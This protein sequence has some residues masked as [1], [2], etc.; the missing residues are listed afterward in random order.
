VGISR[1]SWRRTFVVILRP[2]QQNLFD[3]IQTALRTGIKNPLVV[4]PT[5]S[6]KT[7]LFC[8]IASRARS[9][10][11]DTLILVHRRELVTQTSET[12]RRFDV[13]HGIIQPGITPSLH[14]CV[15]LGMV[16]TIARRLT[17]ITPPKLIIVDEAHHAAAGQY[18]AIIAA[19][20]NAAV[21]GFTA[22]PLRLD[23]KGLG[24][25]FGAILE[26][27]SVEWL[28]KNGFL[29]RP[30]Y[31]APPTCADLSGIK[32]RAGDFASDQLAEAMTKPK[33]TG[34]VIAHYRKICPDA[35]A[36][37]FCVTIAHAEQVCAEFNAAGI[38]S[39]IISGDMASDA[40]K[41]LVADFGAGIVRVLVSVDVVS[42]G[43]D[44]PAVETAILLRK[45]QSL[46]LYL[47]QVGRILRPI[48][49]KQAI[50]L[51]HVGNIAKHGLAEDERTWTLEGVEK[52]EG[53]KNEV[54]RNKQ[55]TG[56]YAVYD[57][58]RNS[59]C[60]ECGHI[61]SPK[62]PEQADGELV[63]IE[64]IAKTPLTHLMK[65]V[66]TRDDLKRIAKAKGYKP[67]W[68]WHASKDLKI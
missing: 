34:D 5:G 64:R 55:C 17:K 44:I 59:S 29:C 63:E 53:K 25:Y 65:E 28:M 39:A 33:V 43:F 23:G 52:S 21:V 27:M 15:Q 56:C 38:T 8:Y 66:K 49:G 57:R 36:V 37:A 11:S 40:R 41:K 62:I 51:D 50:V 58:F 32:K 1:K 10:G 42:E 48:E 3:R 31:Y 46:G 30:K 2:Y 19:F 67:G 18:K 45:T 14:E 35:R 4:S 9:A 12:L 20:P 60:P 54:S 24:D 26:G 47:Q 6:G 61:E 16:Q 7:A 68:I 13:S 22:T